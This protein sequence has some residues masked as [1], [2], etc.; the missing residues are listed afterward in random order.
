MKVR[1]L[2]NFSANFL[3]LVVN[4]VFGLIIFFVLSANLSKIEFGQINL[5]LAILLAV[6]NLLSFGI[7][8]L[9]IKKVASGE[10]PTTLLAL[11]LFHVV[12]SGAFFYLVLFMLYLFWGE[13]SA[14]PQLLLLVGLGK[15][16]IYWSTPFK[17]VACGFER[18]RLWSGMVIISNIARGLALLMLA[19]FH[20]IN[21]NAVILIFITGDAIEL[22]FTIVLFRLNIKIP[23]KPQWNGK[24]YLNLISESIPQAGVVLF[25]SVL[26]RF[27]WIF[28]GLF[29]SA[30]KLSEY[31]F[32]Y[33]IFEISTLPLLAIA[34]LL[35][36]RFTKIFQSEA[37]SGSKNL[38][39]LL[40]IEIAVAILTG[41]ILY[42]IWTP[43]VDYITSGKYGAVNKNTILILVF[44]L[45]LLYINN[46]MWSIYFAK[47]KLKMIFR[48][49]ALTVFVNVAADSILIPIFKNEGAALGYLLSMLAQFVYYYKENKLEQL[50]NIWVSLAICLFGAIISATIALQFF[51]NYLLVSLT[52]ASL[53]IIFLLG[54]KQLNY[55]TITSGIGALE[56]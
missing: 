11:Y 22:I 28:I 21:L 13:K 2:Q 3:Q 10:D 31:S 8:Q 17:Q 35:L 23:L 55:K 47:G 34:P 53:Y 1:L 54:S 5:V 24:Q 19:I 25:T 20:S 29:I 16:M 12:I 45:P 37:S 38:K 6:F 39:D 30:I 42:L 44:C 4:Q 40:N 43:I 7:D 41:L 36:T 48:V 32:A 52:A 15:L 14:L 50:N 33:K 26:A 51:S 18:F 46:F 49:I 9:I 56:H 27:D